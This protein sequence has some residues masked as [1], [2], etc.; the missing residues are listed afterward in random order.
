MSILIVLQET[1]NEARIIHRLAKDN[2]L[3]RED[4][5]L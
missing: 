1:G 3:Y 5:E 2:L 4:N